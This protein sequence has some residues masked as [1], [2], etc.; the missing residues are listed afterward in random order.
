MEIFTN[1]DTTMLRTYDLDA[2]VGKLE[3][4]GLILYPTDTIWGIGC[5]ATNAEAVERVFEL[6]KRE[7]ANPFILLVSSIDMVK[8]YV[9][10]VHPRVE[11]LLAFHDRPLTIV[12]DQAVNLPQN[13]MAPNGSIG[14]RIVKDDFCRQL[15]EQFGRP[16]I[17]T[18]ANISD[19]PF[20]NHFGEISSTVIIGVDHVVKHRRMDKE[21]PGPSPVA[22]IG[23]DSE[24]EFLRG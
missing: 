14:I 19:Q 12:Y 6:K 23:A 20:P 13:V 15:I 5:D 16:I 4:G 10:F 24:L 21:M 11:T 8:N 18:S 7:R 1:P 17:S 3:N 22:R 9:E 2:I